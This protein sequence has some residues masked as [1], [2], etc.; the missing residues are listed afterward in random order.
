VFTSADLSQFI[1]QPQAA[2][3]PADRGVQARISIVMPSYN[4]GH[5][6]E[7]SLLSVLNQNY[8]NTELIVMDGGS[9]DDTRAVLE[10]YGERIELWR[11][12]PDGGQSDALNKGFR[13]VTGEI[14][15]WLNSDDIYCPGAL[16][17][18]AGVFAARPEVQVVYG[19]W[20]TLDLED[21]ITARYFSL[22]FSRAQLITEGFF[23]N[24]QAMFWRRGLHERFG[25][26]DRRLHYTMD[27]D[28]MLRLTGL[29]APSA[30]YRTHRPLGCFRV[31]PGQKTGTAD[32]R[33][34]QEHELIASKEKVS[35]KYG[36]RGRTVRSW[37]RAKRVCDYLQRGGPA[38]VMWKVGLAR[39][40]VENL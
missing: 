12:E 38:Y 32:P 20:F 18:A 9:R 2:T 35:W 33:V 16:E 14:V 28:L 3:A 25:E 29:A 10:R 22:P 31:Y 37:Y 7:R 17:F 30:F 36:L 34:A 27:Y 11:S 23:A 8:P 13:H 1:T 40:P 26:F 19:D 21:R 5:M 39:N 24:A 6:I 15:G 4:H